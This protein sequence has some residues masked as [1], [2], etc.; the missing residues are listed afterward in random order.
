MVTLIRVWPWDGSCGNHVWLA[1]SLIVCVCAH[2]SMRVCLWTTRWY[3][4]DIYSCDGEKLTHLFM[5]L[6]PCHSTLRVNG[7]KPRHNPC[8]EQSMILLV[9]EDSRAVMDVSC[10]RKAV[11]VDRSSILLLCGSFSAPC[12]VCQ[13]GDDLEAA[14]CPQE[15][16]NKGNMIFLSLSPRT[17]QTHTTYHWEGNT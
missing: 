4:S 15:T 2:S 7:F 13:P 9:R 12:Y 17:T 5:L 14:S 10:G 11:R 8:Y 3:P 6:Q 1:C 16:Q